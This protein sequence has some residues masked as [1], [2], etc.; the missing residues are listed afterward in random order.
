MS[1]PSHP[2]ILFLL[3]ILRILNTRSQFRIESR[4]RAGD[5][6]AGRKKKSPAHVT[7]PLPREA[8]PTKGKKKKREKKRERIERNEE[9]IGDILAAEAPLQAL[10]RSDKSHEIN[11]PVTTSRLP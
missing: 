2:L 10:R 9:T 1:S 3:V 6:A 11:F 7:F 5:R 8:G 4:I